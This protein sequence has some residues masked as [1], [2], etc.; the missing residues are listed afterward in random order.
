MFRE[1]G[2]LFNCTWC[3]EDKPALEHFWPYECED[4]SKKKHW[5][6]TIGIFASDEAKA[7]YE[8]KYP[9]FFKSQNDMYHQFLNQGFNI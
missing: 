8:A 1:D 6:G 2:K 7:R 3:L 9:G 5:G 4:C